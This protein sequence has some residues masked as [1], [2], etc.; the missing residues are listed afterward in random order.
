MKLVALDAGHGSNTAGKRTAPFPYPVDID[1]DGEHDIELGEQYREHY[2]NVGVCVFLDEALK[3]CGL[4]TLK[5]AWDDANSKDDPDIDLGVRQRMI[6]SAKCDISISVHFNAFGDGRTFNSADGV[7][8][9]IHSNKSRVGD[10]YSLASRVQKHLAKGTVQRNR[11][12][13]SAGFAMCNCA[14]MG[15]KAA[16]LCELA[17]MTHLKEATTMMASQEFWFEAAE[18]ICQGVC[19]YFN[20]PYIEPQVSLAL[21]QLYRLGVINTPSYWQENYHRIKYLDLLIIKSAEK[22]KKA[23]PSTP[24]VEKG[25]NNLVSAGVINTPNYWIEH[26]SDV[27]YLGDLIQKL[28]GS[29]F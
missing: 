20:I 8:T 15:T 2:A 4:R 14:A 24:T 27:K 29:Q 21:N 10:S 5:V 11:G 26:Q 9:F 6:K 22:I 25:I 17:F 1:G 13:L 19:E 16:I 3:R 28:G 12:V 7:C 18:E 23:G